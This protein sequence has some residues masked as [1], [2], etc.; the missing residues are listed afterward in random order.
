MQNTTNTRSQNTNTKGGNPSGSDRRHQKCSAQNSAKSQTKDSKQKM[1]AG[2]PTSAGH[3][4]KVSDPPVP[5][6]A[7]TEM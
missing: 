7:H 3:A 4:D 6:R 5:N 1:P 2:N